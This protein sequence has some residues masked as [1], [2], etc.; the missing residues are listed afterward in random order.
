MHDAIVTSRCGGGWFGAAARKSASPDL[1]K[2]VDSLPMVGRSKAGSF[3]C[4]L[5]FASTATRRGG[6]V[7]EGSRGA[8]FPCGASGC[9]VLRSLIGIV[10]DFNPTTLNS[11]HCGSGVSIAHLEAPG[12]AA[13]ARTAAHLEPFGV[14][15]HARRM[16]VDRGIGGQTEMPK[17]L[18]ILLVVFTSIAR[19]ALIPWVHVARGSER[20]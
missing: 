13:I 2:F 15:H 8:A 7:D 19:S 18:L 4:P 12:L 5:R 6:S 14:L 3:H 17:H 9:G 20:P 1:R 11:R 16:R 10:Y